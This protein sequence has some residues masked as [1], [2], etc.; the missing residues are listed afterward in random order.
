MGQIRPTLSGLRT[1]NFDNGRFVKYFFVLA[2][3]FASC[4]SATSGEFTVYPDDLGFKRIVF[5]SQPSSK[6]ARV[7]VV[8]HSGEYDLQGTAGQ[9][10]YLEH[11]VYL[12]VNDGKLPTSPDTMSDALQRT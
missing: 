7:T 1:Q 11:L 10:H 2:A 5:V 4:V 12:S 6:R 8:I 3:L 9:A